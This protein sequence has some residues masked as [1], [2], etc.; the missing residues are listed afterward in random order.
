MWVMLFTGQPELAGTV[1][2]QVCLYTKIKSEK[3][4]MQVSIRTV[5]EGGL[6]G[7]LFLEAFIVI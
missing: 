7:N 6:S 5:N 4:K 3:N 1:I 2:C